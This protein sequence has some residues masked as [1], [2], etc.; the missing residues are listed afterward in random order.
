MFHSNCYFGIS[1]Q[2]L[3]SN[4]LYWCPIFF[5]F[6]LAGW[7]SLPFTYLVT[8]CRNTVLSP[9]A[10]LLPNFSAF[11]IWR[12]FD[13][14]NCILLNS[15]ILSVRYYR[16]VI[17]YAQPSLGIFSWSMR[18]SVVCTQQKKL[19]YEQ[20]MHSNDC[21]CHF[22]NSSTSHQFFSHQI[23]C[24]STASLR[25]QR[26]SIALPNE[27]LLRSLHKGFLS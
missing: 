1:K 19:W 8:F 15:F 25:N 12:S 4:W 10:Y 3:I 13:Y 2:W 14:T 21:F 7:L 20:F 6:F 18:I 27:V 16:F 17:I 23:G 22:F 9:R 24:W 5:F 26:K 11:Q